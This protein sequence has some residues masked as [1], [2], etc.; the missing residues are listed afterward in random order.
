MT[1]PTILHALAFFLG[2]ALV[3]AMV[4]IILCSAQPRFDER[5]TCGLIGFAAQRVVSRMM[6]VLR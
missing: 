6:G 5:A 4:F 3:L 2:S 1:R